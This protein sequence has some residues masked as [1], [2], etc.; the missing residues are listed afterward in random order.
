MAKEKELQET[1]KQGTPM[2]PLKIYKMYDINGKID[3][4]YHWHD[5]VE[6]LCIQKGRLSLMVK[7]TLYT[8]EQGEV[9]YINPRELHGMNSLTHDCTYLAFVFPLQWLQFAQADEAGEKYLKPLEKEG[10]Y[11]TNRLPVH[12]AGCAVPVLEKIY[13]LYQEDGDGAWLGIKAGMLLFYYYVYRDRLASR[14]QDNSAYMD[15][16]M[17]ISL[18]IQE[19]C[20]YPLTLETLGRKFHMSPKYFS[21]YFQKHFA[22][23]FSDYLMA[24]RIE[25]AKKLLAGTDAGME[26]VAQQSGFSSSS[27]FIR[28]FRE[29]SGITPG[30]YRKEFKGRQ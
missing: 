11:I 18:Y 2:H 13:S 3:V 4:P 27:Y 1:R 5:N 16:L 19:N 29:T 22:R 21:V 6:I 25:N 24:V 26:L 10:T 30:Q 7:D 9:F 23:N 12:T 28:V 14:R 8:V 20:Q 17:E 15:T